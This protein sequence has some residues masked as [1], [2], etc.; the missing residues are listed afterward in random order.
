[1]EPSDLPKIIIAVDGFA[2]CGKSTL[3]KALAARLGYGYIDS[4]AMYRAA[5]LFLMQKGIHYND[6]AAVAAAL[7]DLHIFFRNTKLGNRTFL[8]NIDVEEE[9]RSMSVSDIVSEVSAISSVRRAMVL[10]QQQMSKQ[11]GVVMDGR[12][13][14]T[15]VFPKAELKIFMT[16]D[17]SIRVQRR[18]AELAA[19]GIHLD[20]ATVEKNLLHRDNIDST[21]ADSPLRKADDAITLDNSFL[22]PAE[23]MEMILAL[24][25]ERII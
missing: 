14:G 12:D 7:P 23:Q 19:K 6:T 18:Q 5:T 21:R 1:M 11:K 2:A 17:V 25:R 8:N 9:V 3:A 4:G 24:A 20:A 15:V 10:Q 13:I 22:T 16:A